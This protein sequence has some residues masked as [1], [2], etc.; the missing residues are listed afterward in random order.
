MSK[1]DSIISDLQQRGVNNADLISLLRAKERELGPYASDEAQTRAALEVL[2]AY[3][4]G[5]APAPAPAPAPTPTPTPRSSSS[6]S[7]DLREV[8]AVIESVF[9]RKQWKYRKSELK[10]GLDLYTLGFN[11]DNWRAGIQMK[12]YVGAD[13]AHCLIV[14]AIPDH[15]EKLYEYN[16]CTL[17]AS[18]NRKIRYGDFKYDESDGEITLEHCL[19]TGKGL[20]PDTFELM[21]RLVLNTADSDTYAPMIRRCAIGKFDESERQDIINRVSSLIKD[22]S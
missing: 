22:L 1:F 12:V 15:C 3:T 6:G 5:E 7:G 17:L 16:L 18:I 13:P 20:N 21:F 8:E 4:K 10:D 19:Y 11:V 14:A 9:A 2:T